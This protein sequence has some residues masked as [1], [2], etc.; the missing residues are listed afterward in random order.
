MGTGRKVAI[1]GMV[2]LA[3][4]MSLTLISAYDWVCMGYGDSLP[5]DP[6]DVE[7][8]SNMCLH[9]VS[10]N[11]FSSK[12][13][14][15]AE[16]PPC[17][18]AGNA[19]LDITPPQLTVNSPSV[20]A[21]Y[22]SRRVVFDLELN[23]PASI[24]YLDNVNGKGRWKKICSNCED[25]YKNSISFKDGLNN[26][27]IRAKDRNNNYNY[28]EVSFWVDSKRPKI[29]RTNP[30]RGF[31][32]GLL[33]MDFVEMNPKKIVLDCGIVGGV[34]VVEEFDS[35]WMDEN[36]V[37]NEKKADKRYCEFDVRENISQF[38]GTEI[39]CFFSLVDIANNSY[40]KGVKKIVVDTTP[41]VLNNVGDFWYQGG[42]RYAKYI[43]FD[44]N[45]TEANLDE[46]RYSYID[47]RG[48][49][50]DKRLC[51]RLKDGVCSTKKSFRNGE[52]LLGVQI[53]DDA[54]NGIVEGVDFVVGY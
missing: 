10:D 27:T 16:S 38:N 44:M 39:S 28:S 26:I 43:Y 52:T 4:F 36:C 17:G 34:R 24:Y 29:S 12:F 42:G 18:A 47:S 11:G 8:W 20:D 1:V 7:C 51:S 21:V 33:S 35:A 5:D 48:T 9:C 3:V 41:P 22:S 49:L 50:R 45:I 6:R 30:R 46:I 19:E 32:N 25:S 31:T 13:E 54:G 15:C 14:H 2:F 23:E 53:I 37:I 40:T